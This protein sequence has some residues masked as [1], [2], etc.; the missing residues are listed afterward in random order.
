LT[1]SPGGPA[2][3]S[4]R[5]TGRPPRW[6]T[7]GLPV[8]LAALIAVAVTAYLL[9]DD[10]ESAAPPP[11]TTVSAGRAVPASELEGEWSGEGSLI[12]CAGFDDDGC[13]E[14]L[15]ITL[16]IVCSG[17]V[18][19]VRPFDRSYG[20]PRLAFSDG[21]YRAAGP[22]PADVAPTCGGVPTRS[23]LWRLELT[24]LDGRLAGDYA[25]STV[26]GFDC[27]ATGVAWR[28]VLERA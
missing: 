14:T 6:A 25:E 4:D 7:V 28:V 2:W 21:R 11:S 3:T 24:V 9:V 18:C 1:D 22:V 27:G 5:S 8:V 16:T 13:A 12:R 23:A 10:Q 17:K 20:S 19:A 26:Q 15:P